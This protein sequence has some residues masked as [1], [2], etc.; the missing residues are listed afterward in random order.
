MFPCIN[1]KSSFF[2]GFSLLIF[3]NDLSLNRKTEFFSLL[4]SLF[5]IFISIIS[6]ISIKRNTRGQFHL[7][8]LGTGWNNISLIH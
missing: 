8:P 1:I 3:Q 4:F 7:V 2:L 6:I 5:S